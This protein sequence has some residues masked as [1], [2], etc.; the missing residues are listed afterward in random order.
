MGKL[1]EE[2]TMIVA[3]NHNLIYGFINDTGIDE[4]EWYGALAITLCEAVKIHDVGR[5]RLS[6]LFYSMAH[7]MV[8]SDL[9]DGMAEKRDDKGLLSLD[10]EFQGSEGGTFTL[11]DIIDSDNVENTQPIEDMMIVQ[12]KLDTLLDGMFGD[13][14]QMRLDGFTQEEVGEELGVSQQYVSVILN[15]LHEDY[16]KL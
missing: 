13:V 3:D 14:V 11:L 15:K 5:G 9:R 1:N 8:R 10:Y 12:E 6:T 2:E 16:Y 4:E 7:N